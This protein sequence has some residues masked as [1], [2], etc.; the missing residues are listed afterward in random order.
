MTEAQLYEKIG[1]QQ[2]DIE[3]RALNYSRLLLLFA[4]V[5]L[6]EVDPARVT[7]DLAAQTWT[8]TPPETTTPGET[9]Q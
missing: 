2:V 8:L 7:L 9:V 3:D 4:Q 5:L 1:R 6:G